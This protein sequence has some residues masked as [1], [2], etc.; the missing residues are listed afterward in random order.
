[1][2]KM[3]MLGVLVAL[4]GCASDLKTLNASLREANAA[5]AGQKMPLR[6]NLAHMQLGDAGG[7]RPT[8]TV[9]VPA[10]VCDR[11]AFDDGVRAGYITSWNQL[12][13]E[14]SK[15]HQL[16]L[17]NKPK[18]GRY[19]ANVQLFKNKVIEAAA[20]PQD[21]QYPMQFGVGA[22][23][24]R[25]RGFVAGKATGRDAAVTEFQAFTKLEA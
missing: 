13:G 6:S 9:N 14:R 1:M 15:V 22:D 17:K 18:D 3:L 12:V 4:T 21:T 7:Y 23:N 8:V 25:Y 16:Q 11:S 10:D 5:L 20:L 2:R 19:Q 24:C